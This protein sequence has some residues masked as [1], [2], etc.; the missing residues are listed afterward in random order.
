MANKSRDEREAERAKQRGD[1]I[2]LGDA[3]PNAKLPGNIRRDGSHPQ[4]IDVRERATGIG[5][6]SQGTGATGID[7]GAGGKG[8]QTKADAPETRRPSR[9]EPEE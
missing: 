7:M 4:G 3:N 8:T 5:D 1:V 9:K 2:G 6:L